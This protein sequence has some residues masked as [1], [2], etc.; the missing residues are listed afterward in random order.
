MTAK[1]VRDVLGDPGSWPHFRYGPG[2][3][4]PDLERA[5]LKSVSENG[6]E[7]NVAIDSNGQEYR[8]TFHLLDAKD[9]QAVFRVLQVAKG[10]RIEDV[11]DFEI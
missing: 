11:G 7:L 3:G 8:S 4:L 6:V 2:S 1:K 5:T 10:S 9:R